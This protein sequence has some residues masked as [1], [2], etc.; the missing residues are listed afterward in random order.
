VIIILSV[1]MIMTVCGVAVLVTKKA[2][3]K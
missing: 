2:I 3:V 1:M